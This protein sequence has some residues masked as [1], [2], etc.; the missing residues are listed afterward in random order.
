M[1]LAGCAFNPRRESAEN[2]AQLTALIRIKISPGAPKP[3]IEIELNFPLGYNDQDTGEGQE[4]AQSLSPPKPFFQQE[5]AKQRHKD[6]RCG[7]DPGRGASLGSSQSVRLQP[8]M[9]RDAQKA[10]QGE[11]SPFL[12]IWQREL[13]A[14]DHGDPKNDHAHRKS[15]PDN[16]DG[17]DILQCDLGGNKRRAPNDHSEQCL[18]VNEQF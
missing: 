9:E 11:I 13:P 4:N 10:K 15:Q 2:T 7:N 12:F 3:P 16:R 8:L 6:R 18:A 17:G 14:Q 5:P 1:R